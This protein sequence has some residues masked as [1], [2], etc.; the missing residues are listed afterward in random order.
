MNHDECDRIE[1]RYVEEINEKR[2]DMFAYRN[3]LIEVCN[4]D[5]KRVTEL[6]QKYAESSA[7]KT[8]PI[9]QAKPGPAAFEVLG[10]MRRSGAA[11]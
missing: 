4:G 7:L 5:M 6:Y 2:R 9:E 10:A 3:A 8:A 1:K 11:P